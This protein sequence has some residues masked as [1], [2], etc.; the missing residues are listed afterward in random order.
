MDM[1]DMIEKL[2]DVADTLKSYID[3]NEHGGP[4][5]AMLALE[6]VQDVIEALMR[7]HASGQ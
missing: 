4:N 6:R 1:N 5:E 3:I 2:E 7:Q